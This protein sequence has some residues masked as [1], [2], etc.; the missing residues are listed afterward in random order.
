MPP[1]VV[2]SL[3]HLQ[4]LCLLSLHSLS[5]SRLAI[6]VAPSLLEASTLQLCDCD[7]SPAMPLTR[8]GATSDDSAE[9]KAE[10]VCWACILEK[11]ARA[12]FGHERW[13][14]P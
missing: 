7:T 10:G 3:P 5:P 6:L 11:S 13:L 4:N 2:S 14:C 1:H 8:G 12:A 9:M